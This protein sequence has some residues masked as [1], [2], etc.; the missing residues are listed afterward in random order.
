MNGKIN[1]LKGK[2][3]LQLEF[4]N[5]ESELTEETRCGRCNVKLEHRTYHV[6]WNPPRYLCDSC[7]SQW[8]ELFFE[9]GLDK[10]SSSGNEELINKIWQ[11]FISL[12][13]CYY[14]PSYR[15]PFK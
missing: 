15:N 6:C 13:P 8:T 12:N 10:A 5:E 7:Q 14:N 4:K 1:G 3:I 11:E 2:K 9:K